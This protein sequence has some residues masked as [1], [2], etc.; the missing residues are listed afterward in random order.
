MKRFQ[1]NNRMATL[2]LALLLLLCPA[3]LS[4]QRPSHNSRP[5]H[6]VPA[7]GKGKGKD[8][9]RLK[10]E[11]FR[12]EFENFILSRVNLTQQEANRF[13]PMFHEM[14]KQQREL[15]GKIHRATERACR[16][17]LS[18]RDCRRILDEVLRLRRQAD[19]IE[20]N[21][22]E[23]F[24]N[25]LPADKLLRVMEAEHEFGKRMWGRGKGKKK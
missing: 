18:Q 11:E 8:G 24:R 14:K 22:Y 10:P 15:R 6:N 19:D 12:R 23:R 7:P 17:N 21:Y 3:T 4:A 5:S 2:W 1:K 13:F 9:K 20:A 25:I 16:E